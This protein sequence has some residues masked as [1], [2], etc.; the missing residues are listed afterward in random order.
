[1]DHR[2]RTPGTAIEPALLPQHRAAT[3]LN[4]AYRKLS[5]GEAITLR[6]RRLSVLRIAHGRVWA[7]LSH[8]GPYSRVLG[9]DDF[10]SRGQ[11]L[12]VLPGQE[13]VMESFES[14]ASTTPATAHFSWE[15]PNAEASALPGAMPASAHQATNTGVLEPLRDLRHALG[16]VAGASGRLV[17]GLAL[18]AATAPLVLLNAMALT[19]VAKRASCSCPDSTFD[20]KKHHVTAQPGSCNAR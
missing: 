4:L 1:M 14:S 7:T 5:A 16:L 11:S 9:G 13:L 15:T 2:L 20:M 6:A 12:T 18:G 10:L 3:A 8:A 17:R 19:L